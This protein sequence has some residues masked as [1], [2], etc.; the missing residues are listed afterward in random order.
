MKL[1]VAILVAATVAVAGCSV[2]KRQDA[3]YQASV[4]RPPLTVPSDLDRPVVDD[5][6]QIPDLAAPG[7]RD[8]RR[9]D[10]P[11]S[12]AGAGSLPGAFM[13]EDSVEGAWRRIGLAL[14]RLGD[15]VS[16]VDAD[17]AA[18][19][20]RV[21]V[22]GRE[23]ADGFFGRLMRRQRNWSEEVDIQLTAAD[24]GIQVAPVGAGREG[25]AVVARLRQR[26]GTL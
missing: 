16:I 23:P 5:M 1:P 4:D 24:G 13:L 10:R 6:L 18:G 2:F 17:Q 12:A 21:M 7:S 26:L 3:D 22:A 11:S 14:A 8:V 19:R 25:Y 9:V 15:D 20:Y